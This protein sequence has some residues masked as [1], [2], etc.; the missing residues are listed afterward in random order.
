MLPFHILRSGRIDK[1]PKG[2]FV[3]AASNP[4]APM[5]IGTGFEGEPWAMFRE[6]ETWGF[7]SLYRFS[8]DVLWVDDITFEVE[9]ASY[10]SLS[11]Q[12]APIGS[13]VFAKGDIAIALP[14]NYGTIP[15]R[16][17]QYDTRE[18][19]RDCAFTNWRAVKVTND[20][21][22]ILWESASAAT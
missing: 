9:P 13:L 7:D 2:S 15:G 1:L 8:T 18:S 16:I 19:D 21:T 22:Y 4:P 14:A 11:S 20:E 12:R 3:L 10:V 5:F 6:E 17:G